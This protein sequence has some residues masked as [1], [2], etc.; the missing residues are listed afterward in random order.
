MA[1]SE[2]VKGVLPDIS[3]GLDMLK[4]NAELR[5]MVVG[6]LRKAVGTGSLT[7]DGSPMSPTHR[8]LF[9]QGI[10]YSVVG[11]LFA[12]TPSMSAMLLLTFLNDAEAS[13]LRLTGVAVIVI[14]Y[15]YLQVWQAN[16][17]VTVSYGLPAA[18]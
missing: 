18:V 3:G 17:K 12:L 15:F 9:L 4:N 16:K 8:F 5:P 11:T 2:F 7:R 1:V 10:F 13:M 14:G 6:L